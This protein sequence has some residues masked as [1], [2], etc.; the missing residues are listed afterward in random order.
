MKIV[1]FGDSLTRGVSYLK[2]RV[3]II[4]DNYPT[5]LQSFFSLN[6]EETIVVNKG[7]FNDN[8]GLL[9]SRL[10][11]DVILEKPNYVLIN[12]GGNDCNFKWEEVAK[13]P[14]EMHEPIV[15][16]A[17]YVNNIK[18]I[19]NQ[20]KEYNITPIILTLPPLDPVRYYEF[21]ASKYGH[22]VSH[23]ISRCGGIEHWHGIYNRQLN[24]LIEQLNVPFIDVRTNLKKSGDL[25][26][27]I[28][29][30]GI[31]LNAAGYKEMSKIIYQNLSRVNEQQL[32]LFE[33]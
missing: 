5:F 28:S 31:H 8:S 9:I 7:V 22:A 2:G 4:K 25:T 20:V 19:I 10:E 15:P 23:W 32:P 14:E 3:R 1:C 33:D 12:I 29:D 24:K 18:N 11:K 27:F 16:V 17:E 21:I 30:D 26:Q 6:Q 13:F